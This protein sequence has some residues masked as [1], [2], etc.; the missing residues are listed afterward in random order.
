MDT[1]QDITIPSTPRS[2]PESDRR[3]SVQSTAAHEASHDLVLT[4]KAILAGGLS[5]K[6]VFLMSDEYGGL[7]RKAPR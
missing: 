6:R 7:N 5:G 2:P 1:D 4:S 3:L